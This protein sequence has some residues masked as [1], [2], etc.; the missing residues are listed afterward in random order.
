MDNLKIANMTLQDFKEIKD[1]LISDF[2][3][4]WSPEVLKNEIIGE[5]KK[6]IVAKLENE[7]IGFCGLM[8][9]FDEI[10]IM[11]IVVKKVYRGKGVG[12]ALLNEIIRISQNLNCKKIFLEVNEKNKPAIKL[13]EKNGFKKIG[14]RKKYY[15]S[16]DDAIIMVI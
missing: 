1:I 13:Y 15:N 16:R 10:E 11:N 12:N 3:D 7:I 4:F 8:I 2:D 6:Y 5:N 14:I 9:N